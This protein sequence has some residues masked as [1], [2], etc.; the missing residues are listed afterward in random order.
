MDDNDD[1]MD[2][3]KNDSHHGSRH[4][5][6]SRGHDSANL[7]G[8]LSGRHPHEGSMGHNSNAATL[9][10]AGPV[11]MLDGS[12]SGPTPPGPPPMGVGQNMGQP[13]PQMQGGNG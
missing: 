12:G 11:P 9:G 6:G 4:G 5:G 8:Q 2:G 7:G 13:P 10:M 1:L 3:G